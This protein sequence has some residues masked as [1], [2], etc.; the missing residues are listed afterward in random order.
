[1]IIFDAPMQ[2]EIRN[3]GDQLRSLG[4]QLT[5]DQIVTTEMGDATARRRMVVV[6]CKVVRDDQARLTLEPRRTAAAK[7]ANFLDPVEK[8]LPSDWLNE[9][10]WDLKLDPKIKMVSAVFM[11]KVVGKIHPKEENGRNL[12][13]VYTTDGPLPLLTRKQIQEHGIFLYIPEGKPLGVRKIKPIEVWRIHGGSDDDWSSLVK[14]GASEDDLTAWAARS[15]PKRSAR[16]ILEAALEWAL[17][18]QSGT[19]VGGPRHREQEEIARITLDWCKSWMAHPEDPRIGLP[20]ASWWGRSGPSEMMKYQEE[21]VGM[22]SKF[23]DGAKRRVKFVQT[24]AE[25][26]EFV[27]EGGGKGATRKVRHRKRKEVKNGRLPTTF[28]AELGDE[29][30]EPCED[31]D[32]PGTPV[33][34]PGRDANWMDQMKSKPMLQCLAAGTQSGYESSWRAWM[35]YCRLRRTSP[36]LLGRTHEEI[37]ED[38]EEI[39]TYIVHLTE[40]L[41]RAPGTVRGHISAIRN[42]HVQSGWGGPFESRPRVWRAVRGLEKARG[43]TARKWPVT[44]A[45]MK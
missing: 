10:E 13:F 32:Q 4:Y 26:R 3:A 28:N 19:V 21:K 7:C 9:A 30:L 35:L 34:S 5:V 16:S 1:M 20:P 38:E 8:T 15:L 2:V 11:P 6:A 27:V 29:P 45:M 14:T 43:T 39:L 25:V 44:T 12:H 24:P 17:T 18:S 33:I 36:F 23:H 22:V 40:N 41:T 31:V 42:M 37:K